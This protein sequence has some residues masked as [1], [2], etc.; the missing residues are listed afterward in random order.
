M[1]RSEAHARRDATIR[2]GL[3][4]IEAS[5]QASP[6]KDVIASECQRLETAVKIEDVPHSNG[7][8]IHWIGN[9]SPKNVVLYFHGGG[10]AFPAIP[11]H[12]IFWIQSQQRMAAKG[13]AFAVAMVEYGM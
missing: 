13:K 2:A 11:G 5:R 8:R 12:V 4:D 3:N 7:A 6:T 10:F 9:T 1:A